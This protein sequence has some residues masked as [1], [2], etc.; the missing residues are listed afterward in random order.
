MNKKLFKLKKDS[1]IKNIDDR[2]DKYRK[3]KLKDFP[4]KQE[5]VS[6]NTIIA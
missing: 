2:M 1:S 5:A 4:E 3:Q 6:L